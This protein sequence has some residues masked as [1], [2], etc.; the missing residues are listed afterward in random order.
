MNGRRQTA[1]TTLLLLMIVGGIVFA[2]L[3][4]VLMAYVPALTR[5]GA[6]TMVGVPAISFNLAVIKFSFSL[7]VKVNLFTIIGFIAGYFVF[8]RL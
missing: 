4:E 3:G 1:W 2:Y 6:G 8:R 5:W 7:L